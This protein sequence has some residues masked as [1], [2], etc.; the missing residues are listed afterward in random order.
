MQSQ[1]PSGWSASRENPPG[2]SSVESV[3]DKG[4]TECFRGE[5]I[6]PVSWIIVALVVLAGCQ[7]NSDCVRDYRADQD[8]NCYSHTEPHP[9]PHANHNTDAYDN[10]KEALHVTQRHPD[11][12]PTKPEQDANGH[13]TRTATHYHA[14]RLQACRRLAARCR[15]VWRRWR[16]SRYVVRSW[17]TVMARLGAI[18][19]AQ[20]V[21][22]PAVILLWERLPAIRSMHR[23]I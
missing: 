18:E 6:N 7:G 10:R 13:A 21:T 20:T 4:E 15:A 16:A 11:G 1:L 14:T 9:G 5:R 19:V 23:F 3:T 17:R 22:T 12:T 8:G 2:P